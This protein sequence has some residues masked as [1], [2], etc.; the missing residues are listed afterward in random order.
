MVF[1]CA[2]WYL[3]VI[4]NCTQFLKNCHLIPDECQITQQ[5]KINTR[6]RNISICTEMLNLNHIISEEFG[7]YWNHGL[8][9]LQ[10]ILKIAKSGY[11]LHFYFTFKGW[12]LGDDPFLLTVIFSIFFWGGNVRFLQMHHNWVLLLKWNLVKVNLSASRRILQSQIGDSTEL[13]IVLL[14]IET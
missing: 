5:E 2:V 13:L 10:K 12:F 7:F 11:W 4:Q 6:N 3:K 1:L 8:H 9:F 14:C